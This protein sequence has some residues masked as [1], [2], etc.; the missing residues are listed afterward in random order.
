MEIENLRAYIP[1]KEVFHY[2]DT[3]V[4]RGLVKCYDA[5]FCPK[6]TITKAEATVISRSKLPLPSSP[7][8]HI[9]NIYKSI[10]KPRE[11]QILAGMVL[12][13]NEMD[14]ELKNDLASAGLI[15]LIVASGMNLTLVGGFCFALFTGFGIH[16][17]AVVLVSSIAVLLYS[18]LTGF[19]PPIVRALIMFE[20]VMLG[21]LVG[22]KSGG[23]FALLIAGY[24]MLWVDP[25][26]STSYSFLLSFASMMGQIFVGTIK[27][28]LPTPIQAISLVV[29]Q[30]FFALVFTLPIILIGFA[31]FSLVSILTNLL[32]IWMIEPLMML[33]S[34]AGIVGLLSTG[35][36]RIA[37]TPISYML[38]LFI[39]VVDMFGKGNRFVWKIEDFNI[40]IAIGYYLLLFASIYYFSIHYSKRHLQ[41]TK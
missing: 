12:G 13:A 19:N 28:K 32:V 14:R 38:E 1:V 27:L 31:R 33:G 6:G 5:F 10:L 16:R 35:V 23:L 24:L 15:H 36:A 21:G 39:W 20:A 40:S 17:R 37:L 22:R 30:N 8:L 34:L 41:V 7:R 4:L 26:L 2:G 11:A 9:I 3:V 18:A 25:S 29:L